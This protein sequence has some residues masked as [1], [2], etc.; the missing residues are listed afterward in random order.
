MPVE[1]QRVV[2]FSPCHGTYLAVAALLGHMRC[3]HCVLEVPTARAQLS[4]PAHCKWSL[5]A[6]T[7]SAL[8]TVRHTMAL[9]AGSCSFAS[10]GMKLPF[11]ACGSAVLSLVAAIVAC[12]VVIAVVAHALA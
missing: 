3:P 5:A 11:V 9:T 8:L 12:S 7:S 6:C 4:E 10:S 2:A 1:L